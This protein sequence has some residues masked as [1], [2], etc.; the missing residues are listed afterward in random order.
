[1]G[2]Y[3]SKKQWKWAF[4]NKKS[5]ARRWAHNTPDAKVKRYKRLPNKV[6]KHG[7]GKKK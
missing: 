6:R 7:K 4:A 2:H 3:R 5:F 1:M